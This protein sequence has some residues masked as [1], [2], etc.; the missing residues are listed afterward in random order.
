MF[1]GLFGASFG[2]RVFSMLALK[3]M[4]VLTSMHMH[5]VADEADARAWLSDQKR[6][7][8]ARKRATQRL[9]G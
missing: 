4:A 7:W 6:A 9:E 5:A 1:I 3:A 8:T 2:M